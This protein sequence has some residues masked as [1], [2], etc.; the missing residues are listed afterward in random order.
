M[1]EADIQRRV[2]RTIDECRMFDIEPEPRTIAEIMID[3]DVTAGMYEDL[4][5]KRA[6]ALGEYEKAAARAL[7]IVDRRSA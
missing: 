4:S 1:D 7:G 2:E 5:A 3:E 6:I